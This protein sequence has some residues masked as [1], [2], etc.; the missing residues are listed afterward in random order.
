MNGTSNQPDLDPCGCCETENSLPVVHNRP[1]LSALLYRIGTHP[2]F[3]RRML[4]RL[5]S[6]R[7]P[8]SN[9][10]PL[11]ALTTRSRADP[12]IALLD[13][14]A[15]V[16]DVL[17][18]YQERIANEGYLRTATER[19][20]VLDLARTIGYELRPG[21]SAQAYL[22]LLVEDAAGS[23]GVATVPQGTKVQSVPGQGQTPQ[24]FE[25]STEIFT[26]AEWNALRP[27][28]TRP[29]ELAIR[30]GKLYALS[31]STDF[32]AEVTT[33]ALPV[34][35]VYPLDTNISLPSG[36]V[37]GVEVKQIDLVGT[38]TNLKL[39][40]LILLVGSKSNKDVQTLPL[41]I[42]RL[43]VDIAL[44][45]TRV[46]LAR[47]EV[48]EPPKRLTF[49]PLA[50]RLAPLALGSVSFTRRAIRSS[51][52]QQTWRERDLTAFVS[53]QRDWSKR[54][55]IRFVNF[56]PAPLPPPT[57]PPTNPGI[58]RFGEK[59]GIFGHNAPLYK[60]LPV[61]LRRTIAPDTDPAA[62]PHSW[63]NAG[64]EI[65][66]DS[67][68]NANYTDADVYLE[69]GVSGLVN[70][71]WSVFERPGKNYEVYRIRD[72]SDA[73]L[74]GFSISGKATGLQLAKRDGTDLTD[75]DKSTN[76]KVRTTTA[77]VQSDRLTLSLL[78]IEDALKQGST[79]L[80]LGRMVM[81]LKVGQ[82]VILTG[83]LED[84]Q[85]IIRSEVLFLEEIEHS[86]GYTTLTFK[87]GLKNSYVRKTVTLN[88]NVVQATHGETVN[89]VL[90]S[91]DGTKP[92]QRFKLKKPPLTYLSAATASGTQSTLQV[93]V[94]GVLWQESDRLFGLDSHSKNYIVRIEDDG[95]TQ[96]I[97]GDG[98]IGARLSTGAENLVATYRSGIG[99]AGML[100]ADKLTLLQTRPLG[101]RSVTNPL[102]TSGAAEPESR[103]SA[104]INAPLTVLTLDRI[105]SLQ[106]FEDFAQAFAGI[107]KAKA[108]A[109]WKGESQIVHLTVA[110]AAALVPPDEDE[111][112]P[113]LAS[114]VIDT[115]SDLY[116]N[117]MTSIRNACDPAHRFVVQS[118]EP[119]Y[120]NLRAKVQIDERYLFNIVLAAVEAA[121]KDTFSFERRSF[122]QSVTAA[123]VITVIQKVKGVIATD[124]V[125]LFAYVELP[126]NS[127]DDNLVIPPPPDPNQE[128]INDPL[129]VEP[130]KQLT[131]QAKLL[132]INPIGIVLEE[133]KP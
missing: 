119:R 90:G 42:Q 9:T 35:E 61:N 127:T 6:A 4:N 23:P 109:L 31:I 78:P 22:A 17:T 32:G 104:R 94:N 75:T 130:V 98:K 14:W 12:A 91:G 21:V 69:R 58:F 52:L 71:S 70:N 116:I 36:A 92:N 121:L 129:T 39:G 131:D 40:D 38:T 74:T 114:H 100:G 107:G 111:V 66:K 105:V 63:D 117:L 84:L 83:E 59:L 101:I 115:N 44:N 93:R 96:L 126:A 33:V 85:S 1:G 25:T 29:Q 3:L 128:V 99:F 103:D 62:Y 88:A 97:F 122:G 95:T 18:F 49:K 60:S 132:L 108:I 86:G 50:F 27:R 2:S 54:S 11:N 13:A 43:E 53:I 102:S 68:T 76:F 89:E 112:T 113:A 81:D 106:D 118:Y 19:R 7:I 57:L 5:G 45:R 72:A 16:A 26:R 120:F 124:L 125:H 82:P 64:W 56:T 41:V 34:S 55:L 30:G 28:L 110:A 20:S 80:Q 46:D 67:L 65:W 133:M 77:Y 48:F 123:E 8:I 87:T 51:I 24:T 79:E 47:E 37:K 10:Y 73:S 15:T